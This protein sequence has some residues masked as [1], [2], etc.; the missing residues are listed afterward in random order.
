MWQIHANAGSTSRN[1]LFAIPAHITDNTAVLESLQFY[2]M[3]SILVD[4][5]SLTKHGTVPLEA[6]L[7]YDAVKHPEFSFSLLVP[8][9]ALLCSHQLTYAELQLAG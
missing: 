3:T 5:Q 4:I 9:P 6:A 2:L 8:C 7:T 1:R